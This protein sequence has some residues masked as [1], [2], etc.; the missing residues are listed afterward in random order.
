MKIGDLISGSSAVR[1]FARIT[2]KGA[3][4]AAAREIRALAARKD[5]KFN[6]YFP[7]ED[8]VDPISGKILFHARRKYPRHLVF[9]KA[10][11][12]YRFRCF[13]AANRIGKTEAAAYEIALH[14]TGI[15]PHWW[16]GKRFNTPTEWWFAN[17]SWEKVR[18][19]NQA[20]LLGNPQRP[21]EMGSGFIPRELLVRHNY[22]G[23][24]KYGVDTIAVRHIS[25]GTSLGQF[26]AYTQG[27]TSF[28][29]NAKHGVWLDEEVEVDVNSA[30]E[31]RI[32]TLD[33]VII[34]TYTPVLGLTE[35]TEIYEREAVK[36]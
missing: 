7:D 4:D 21:E 30:C 2:A 28:E 20:A 35:M 13:R 6:T 5:H 9:F 18:D 16:E 34:M 11:K 10:G 27:S 12:I 24:T 31:M 1:E 14:M 17:I 33:G 23:F 15:Y 36:L 32:M 22:H 29:S 19:V 8:I 25:G 26:K 3:G